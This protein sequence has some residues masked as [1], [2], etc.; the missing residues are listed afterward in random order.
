MRSAID[1]GVLS[2]LPIP[3]AAP[4]Y[5]HQSLSEAM[6]EKTAFD[7][8]KWLSVSYSVPAGVDRLVNTTDP[9]LF[10]SPLLG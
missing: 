8:K 4:A 10:R 3:P 5:L 1:W 9:W 2:F 7:R 6:L